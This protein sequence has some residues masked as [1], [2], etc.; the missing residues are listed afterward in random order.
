MGLMELDNNMVFYFPCEPKQIVHQCGE[1]I[2]P[3]QG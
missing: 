3:Y 1:L 2:L